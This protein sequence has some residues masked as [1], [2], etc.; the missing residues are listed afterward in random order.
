MTFT[1][2]FQF[3]HFLNQWAE[4]CLHA[5]SLH[6]FVE[7]AEHFLQFISIE[8]GNQCCTCFA[9]WILLDVVLDEFVHTLKEWRAFLFVEFGDSFLALVLL[10]H[11]F[12]FLLEVHH[13]LHGRFES[14]VHFL[15]VGIELRTIH[16]GIFPSTAQLT[17]FAW[18]T[19]NHGD[20]FIRCRWF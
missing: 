11:V 7:V 4:D 19:I 6:T 1:H 10:H 16:F 15:V 14:I 8:I 3:F 17:S 18:H 5:P 2:L 20:I 12:N 9:L 13:L